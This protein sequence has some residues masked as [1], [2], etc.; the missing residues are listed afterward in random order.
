MYRCVKFSSVSLPV[1][2][3]EKSFASLVV[4]PIIRALETW[5][6]EAIP[7][8]DV[9]PFAVTQ[10]RLELSGL[11]QPLRVAHLTDLHFGPA[12]R[13][14][15]VRAWVNATLEQKPDLI[16]ITGDF[17]EGLLGLHGFTAIVVERAGG[18]EVRRI[19]GGGEGG[20]DEGGDRKEEGGGLVHQLL[21]PVN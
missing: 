11:E 9:M 16:L 14:P 1:M 6:L 4:K 5:I 19:R 12:Q 10:H 20:G 7:T 15:S 3:A 21:L 17:L 8:P 18:G 2:P 13:L